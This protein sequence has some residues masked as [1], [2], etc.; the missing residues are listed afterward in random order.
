MQ[1]ERTAREKLAFVM[2]RRQFVKGVAAGSVI[3]GLEFGGVQPLFGEAGFH[4]PT[5]LTGSHFE[6]TVDKLPVNFTGKRSL[7]TA[8]NGSVTG[9]TLRWSEGDV[10]TVAVTNRL[11]TPTSI[12]WHGVRLPTEMDGVPGLSF[13]GI[14]PGERFVYRIPVL[15]SGT[16]WYHSHSGGQEQAGLSGALILERK[17]KDSIAFDREY[18]VLL[19]DWTDTNPEIV[20][21]N[22][23]EESEYYNYHQRTAATFFSDV[24]KK[25]LRPTLSER[26]MWGRMNMTPTDIADVTGAT[27]TYLLNGN[28][29]NANWTGLFQPGER[30]RLRFING[31]SMTFFDVRIPGLPMTVVQSDGNDVEPVTIDEFRI[32]LAETYDVIVEPKESAAYTIFAQ[33]QDRTGY[34]RGTLAPRMSMTAAIPPMDPRP[35]RTM[36]DMGMS[37]GGMQMG[38]MKASGESQTAT[39]QDMAGMD[40][41]DMDMSGDMSG[42]DMGDSVKTPSP[43]TPGAKPMRDSMAGMA[44]GDGTGTR[45]FPQPGPHTMAVGDFSSA[46]GTVKVTDPVKLHLGPEVDMISRNVIDRLKDPGDGLKGNGRRVLTYADLRNRYGG[47]DGRP[48]TREIEL[49]LTG[50]ME[51]YIWGFN[52]KR[53]SEAKPIELKL[54]ERVRF[55]LINDTMMEHPIHLHGLWSE[56]ENG[57]GEFNPYK[58]TVIVKPSERVSYLVSADTP[59]RWALHCHLMYHMDAGMFRAVVVS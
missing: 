33:A 24:K 18:A 6:L 58:H 39:Q 7:A 37:M 52:G 11:K 46:Q 56:L 31:S 5:T 12:H 32:G 13:A 50:N 9:P 29:P 57:H 47:V 36:I 27:Y 59:G 45:P 20:M 21:S 23:K 34:A 44:M 14:A 22:L 55:V 49:H 16:Y 42:M 2:S 54:G 3:A 19:T 15:Q 38:G 48:P 8:V 1:K 30:V 28:T 35:V 17:G 53:F 41:S 10:V 25:G 4:T 26:L 51:R 43:T 40:M